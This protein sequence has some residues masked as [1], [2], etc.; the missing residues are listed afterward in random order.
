MNKPKYLVCFNR[1]DERDFVLH[2]EKPR[3][4]MSFREPN[5][6]GSISSEEVEF[7]DPEPEDANKI[8]RLM[9]EAGQIYADHNK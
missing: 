8:A 2:T 7:I 5:E 6:D 1:E 4:L 9:R 3:F